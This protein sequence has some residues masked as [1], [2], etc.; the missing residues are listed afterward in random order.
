MQ[1]SIGSLTQKLVHKVKSKSSRSSAIFVSLLGGILLTAVAHLQ[2]KRPDDLDECSSEQ[3]NERRRLAVSDTVEWLINRFNKTESYVEIVGQLD[4]KVELIYEDSIDCDIAGVSGETKLWYVPYGVDEDGLKAAIQ[5]VFNANHLACDSFVN[6]WD[7]SVVDEYDL[8]ESLNSPTSLPSSLPSPLPSSLP[9][10]LPTTDD[11]SSTTIIT[12]DNSCVHFNANLVWP[13]FVDYWDGLWMD[14]GVLWGQGNEFYTEIY[15]SQGGAC[16]FYD[17][18]ENNTLKAATCPSD[19][20]EKGIFDLANIT[21]IF[22]ACIKEYYEDRED[23]L[24]VYVSD[25]AQCIKNRL[26][27]H[28]A[29]VEMSHKSSNIQVQL[30]TEAIATFLYFSTM[31]LMFNAGLFL[32]WFLADKCVDQ[33]KKE[34]KEFTELI[35]GFQKKIE[36]NDCYKQDSKDF[37][38]DF[39]DV[40]KPLLTK[41]S[42]TDQIKLGHSINVIIMGIKKLGFEQLTDNEKFEKEITAFMKSV[43]VVVKEIVDDFK[44]K[45]ESVNVKTKSVNFTAFSQKIYKWFAD[46]DQGKFPLDLFTYTDGDFKREV[47]K[48]YNLCIQS[49][50]KKQSV[51]EGLAKK[52]NNKSDSLQDFYLDPNI[53]PNIDVGYHEDE[54]T[55]TVIFTQGNEVEKIDFDS[56]K[57]YMFNN[58]GLRKITWDLESL[59][60]NNSIRV[61][62]IPEHN[63]LAIIENK[64]TTLSQETTATQQGIP[65]DINKNSERVVLDWSMKNLKRLSQYIRTKDSANVELKGLI[66]E[67][68]FD[69]KSFEVAGVKVNFVE[70]QR[71]LKMDY[72]GDECGKDTTEFKFIVKHVEQATVN[73]L[74]FSGKLQKRIDKVKKKDIS[75]ILKT[76]LKLEAYKTKEKLVFIEINDQL[77]EITISNYSS[78]KA[79]I[80]WSLNGNSPID[81]TKNP[82]QWIETQISSE[83]KSPQFDHNHINSF[84]G[85]AEDELTQYST[86]GVSPQVAANNG[87]P[88]V[89]TP[90]TSLQA[91]AHSASLQ[92]AAH[93]ASPQVST[94]VTSLQAVKHSAS[95]QD[96]TQGESRQGSPE[97]Y[98]IINSLLFKVIPIKKDRK[99]LE[100]AINKLSINS[101]ANDDDSK[102]KELLNRFNF[103]MDLTWNHEDWI[104]DDNKHMDQVKLATLAQSLGEDKLFIYSTIDR[105]LTIM[106]SD[107]SQKPACESQPGE[108]D[109]ILIYN[110]LHYAYAEFFGKT[111]IEVSKTSNSGTEESKNSNGGTEESKSNNDDV[112]VSKISNGGADAELGLASSNIGDDMIV[113]KIQLDEDK[114]IITLFMNTGWN[115]QYTYHTEESTEPLEKRML[116][117]I[118]DPLVGFNNEDVERV[119][120]VDIDGKV[121]LVDD[122]NFGE[123][124]DL[125]ED[126]ECSGAEEAAQ[127]R[128]RQVYEA[129][130]KHNGIAMK[131]KTASLQILDLFIFLNSKID[132]LSRLSQ[133]ATLYTDLNPILLCINDEDICKEITKTI[134]GEIESQVTQVCTDKKKTRALSQ[135]KRTIKANGLFEM[136]KTWNDTHKLFSG[137][138]MDEIEKLCKKYDIWYRLDKFRQKGG[139]E[140]EEKIHNSLLGIYSSPSMLSFLIENQEELKITITKF[141]KVLRETKGCFQSNKKSEEN[142]FLLI[143]YNDGWKCLDRKL[144]DDDLMSELTEAGLIEYNLILPSNRVPANVKEPISKDEM[145]H[146]DNQLFMSNVSPVGFKTPTRDVSSVSSFS[147]QRSTGTKPVNL[148]SRHCTFDR[149]FE[150][151]LDTA[152]DSQIIETESEIESESTLFQG[153]DADQQYGI[154]LDSGS[155]IEVGSVKSDLSLSAGIPAEAS[156]NIFEEQRKSKLESYSSNQGNSGTV[157]TW[158]TDK[159]MPRI[160]NFVRRGSSLTFIPS[161]IGDS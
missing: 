134:K 7:S 58:S 146:H 158:L 25:G 140:Q 31:F 85:L 24:A 45:N 125:D 4:R 96:S 115:I 52:L 117:L 123:D 62:I 111:E 80:K 82:I 145:T 81:E 160:A 110:G 27:K 6:D 38:A 148:S 156:E 87:L 63:Y 40:V 136:F 91:A 59:S 61:T 86:L 33:M 75:N 126:D 142:L 122:C 119:E 105:D 53:W 36:N 133:R 116:S 155:E 131:S 102:A 84:T 149:L 89:S 11:H 118:A 161:N 21:K 48:A 83:L 70:R 55:H 139:D 3:G 12:S 50:L 76:L 152:D 35:D 144:V 44:N 130:V 28:H 30:H 135:F 51:I 18:P 14:F 32:I 42:I 124:S 41:R 2:I 109:K 74:Y 34:P 69:V 71:T 73:E 141:D 138:K 39:N 153:H 99:S 9:S 103:M 128:N 120:L 147:T 26:G 49:P 137:T 16:V 151:L 107:G 22:D 77:Y 121:I 97:D 127:K 92:G 56:S 132:V 37:I 43:M 13:E 15:P 66:K 47:L 10:S 23:G 93:N 79:H 19:Y 112:E 65:D 98:L 113:Q 95:L 1:D 90:G 46:L 157:S 67:K 159:G 143:R 68:D 114:K 101:L 154:N 72:K 88:Q 78:K 129:V 104:K 106:G 94:P 29:C 108:A 57:K 64:D 8:S 54:H 17:R 20:C 60:T 100:S 150:S 5:S